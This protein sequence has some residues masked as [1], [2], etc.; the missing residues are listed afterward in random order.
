MEYLDENNP[1]RNI[2]LSISLNN[3][4]VFHF[5]N[6]NKKQFYSCNKV[7]DSLSGLSGPSSLG[8]PNG[9]GDEEIYLPE[10]HRIFYAFDKI[11]NNNNIYPKVVIIGQDC[12][13]GFLRNMKPQACGLA[14]SVEGNGKEIPSSLLNIFKN[15]IKFNHI[16]SIP[17]GN[18]D[19]LAE[20]GVLLLNT[21]LTVQKHKPNSHSNIWK[22]FTDDIISYISDNSTSTIFVLWGNH[23]LMKQKLIDNKKHKLIISS[24]PSGLSCNKRLKDYPS[25]V[26]NDH[27]GK[28]NSYLKESDKI[29]FDKDIYY[30]KNEKS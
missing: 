30:H 22:G 16:N 25:F 11:K 29:I 28:I 1:W 3:I 4:K 15:M 12:Y 14:F 20:Q 18:L 27:F 21:S 7:E 5:L 8:G 13:H 2:L 17:D 10:Y 9:P 19:Y 24:H 6:N 26:E 23:S